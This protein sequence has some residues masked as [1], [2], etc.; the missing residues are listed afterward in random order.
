[1]S[2]IDANSHGD[3]CPACGRGDALSKVWPSFNGRDCRTCYGLNREQHL[4][5][6]FHFDV[7]SGK[8]LS[9]KSPKSFKFTEL[10]SRGQAISVRDFPAEFLYDH[11]KVVHVKALDIGD[12]YTNEGG[13][14]EWAKGHEAEG[15]VI[16]AIPF[17][18]GSEVVGLQLRAF[19]PKTGDGPNTHEYIRNVGQEGV[20]IPEF[21]AINP[22]AVVIHEG[23]W[24]AI[25]A[26]YDAKE[27]NNHE[28]ISVAAAS[29]N[30]KPQTIQGTLD[31]IFPG[32][33]RFAF[34]DQDPAGIKAREAL[35]G[36][37][38]PFLVTGAG[39]GKDYRDLDPDLRFEA[40]VRS[41][42]PLLLQQEEHGVVSYP[43]DQ[44][45]ELLDERLSWFIQTEFGLAE[46][47]RVRWGA[48]CMFIEAWGKWIV[49]Q[50]GRWVVSD[51]KAE[52]YAQDAIKALMREA[53]IAE[54]G[55][56]GDGTE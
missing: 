11:C 27:Y 48:I 47:F 31:A 2:T 50:D 33:P 23:P 4:G 9:S 55:H 1:V 46:R 32:V 26:H 15:W 40:F 16:T 56:D 35:K 39:S 17:H 6:K 49:Y 44:Q 13:Y 41:I 14:Y 37:A 5:R 10:F 18:A 52:F 24:G 51:L 36:I 38:Q 29:A 25:A 30:T 42:K 3:V 34:F 7:E 22:S 28:L 21:K 45:Q 54:G 20:Y 43:Q 12:I 53:S 19:N 8:E